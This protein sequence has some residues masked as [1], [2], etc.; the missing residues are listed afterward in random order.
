MNLFDAPQPNLFDEGF[1]NVNVL[2][3][4]TDESVSREARL[5]AVS[6]MTPDDGLVTGMQELTERYHRLIQLEGDGAVRREAAMNQ[7]T[8]ELEALGGLMQNTTGFDE[9]GSIAEGAS[10]ALRQAVIEDVTAREAFA[11]EQEALQN[12][13]NLAA[14]GDYTQAKILMNNL[15]GDPEDRIRD[16]NVKNLIA[17]RA[18]EKAGV[19]KESQGW[20]SD[21]VDFA[22]NFVPIQSGLS[23][24]GL[25]DIDETYK[26]WWDGLLPG[27]RNRTEAATLQ[28]MDVKDFAK[29]MEDLI[30]R[31]HD[32]TTLMGIHSN[33]EE[34]E[35]LSS[36]V[37]RTPSALATNAFTLVDNVGLLGVKELRAI[38]SVP[39]LLLRMGARKE[40]QN[41]I[42]QAAM[43]MTTEGAEQAA[44][45]TGVSVGEVVQGLSPKAINIDGPIGVVAPSTGAN[46]ALSEGR[47]MLAQL[48]AS[49]A[50]ARLTDDE[51][52]VAQASTLKKATDRPIKDVEYV[53]VQTADG[54][55]VN[56][57]RITIGKSDG[58]GYASERYAKN[59]AKSLGYT[60]APIIRDESGQ[61]FVQLDLSVREQGFATNVMNVKAT[62]FLSR[63]ILNSNMLSDE[64]LA[65]MA[66]VAGNKKGKLLDSMA[67]TLQAPFRALKSDE[68]ETLS[69]ILAVGENQG[70]WFTE[71]ELNVL[72]RRAY[73]RDISANEVKA[74]H[75]ARKINDMEFALRNDEAY[76]NLNIKGYETV[77][78]NTGMG[79]VDN[80]SAIVVR[81][82]ESADMGRVY[83]VTYKRHWTT[84]PTADDLKRMQNEGF[85][86]V[87]LQHPVKMADGTVIRQFV[88]K[89]NDIK[90][91]PLKQNQ[92]AYRAGGH[93]MYKGKYFVKQTVK[94]VQP[95]TGKA[96]IKSP[97]TYI[98]AETP[99]EASFW[100][101]KMEAARQVYKKGNATPS[102]IDA[103]FDGYA[104]FEKGDVFIKRMK[105]GDYDADHAFVVK[106]DREMPDEYFE[107]DMDIQ[108]F[109]DMDEAAYDGLLRTNGRMY[110]SKKGDVLKDWQGAQAPT[111]DPFLVIDKSLNN[112]AN[113]TSMSDYKISAM[114]RWINTYG[115]YLDLNDLNPDKI[116][117]FL[118]STVN[119]G[120]NTRIRQAAETQRE[121]IKRN[122]GWKSELDLEAEQYQ[123]NIANWVSGTD[124]LSPQNKAL[125][126][127]TDWWQEKDPIVGLRSMAFDM[128]MGFFNVAQLPMQIQTA[129]AATMLSPKSG[130]HGFAMYPSLRYFLTNA[131][132]ENA[133]DTFVKRGVHNLSGFDDPND[134][135]QMM[136]SAKQSGFFNVATTHNLVARYG[137]GSVT[138]SQV[139]ASDG[140]LRTTGR[141]F[142]NEGEI[143]NRTVAWRIA[144]DEARTKLSGV[145]AMSPAFQREVAGRAEKYSFSM[146][147]QSAA[148]WQKGVLSV[149]T[150][151]WAYNVRMMEAMLGGE[152]TK[153]QRV[154]LVIGQTLLYGSSGLPVMSYVTDK[155]KEHNAPNM[156]VTQSTLQ[157]FWGAADRGL[158][159]TALYYASGGNID[160]MVGKRYGTGGFLP[161][162]IKDI[163]GVSSYGEK[164]FYDIAAGATA[165]IMGTTAKGLFD[166][167]KY[168]S[169]ETGAEIEGMPLTRDAVL[170]VALNLSTVGN[171]YKAYMVHQYGTAMSNKGATAAADL[172]S[173]QAFATAMSLQSG[174]Q[175]QISTLMAYNKE[176]KK[177]RDEATKIIQNLRTRRLNEP[178]N[179]EELTR[180]INIHYQ[181][182]DEE[183]RKEVQQKVRQT[184]D[185]SLWDGM[186][187][188][189]Q[190]EQT[191]N[192]LMEEVENGVIN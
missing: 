145:D 96:F 53:T 85:M 135:K 187:R 92:L 76:K 46:E 38:A 52:A 181:L 126:V 67:E 42:A 89:G 112:I 74:Y 97:N 101:N 125:K 179:D 156:D 35:L 33:S 25:I 13:Q 138:G 124:P 109:A 178:D 58:D 50:T 32:K 49:T 18:M 170:S 57:A 132:S 87:N 62:N 64:L 172:P 106:F 150:Q 3:T 43:Q 77:E 121:I 55:Q 81:D 83:D 82:L 2:D 184:Q 31:L 37:E 99:A 6:K 162:T 36:L 24:S 90:I 75:T 151:F 169:A 91:S 120:V 188:K 166:V 127:V 78:F 69:Q 122:L 26:N 168:A 80:V 105:D 72:T 103:V 131:G 190:E 173:M 68:R 164:S 93:R 23:K 146:S 4:R 183:L 149:P 45:K 185:K 176:K 116:S 95:D 19:A 153:A 130:M 128:K 84:K 119:R 182:M 142:F 107:K 171:A 157:N 102:D 113:I 8:R 118:D 65:N 34:L 161:E 175:D 140:A 47:R 66:Q 40:A 98:V 165:G 9:D 79:V 16:T 144:W 60:D 177:I 41:L 110:Y 29:A 155:I 73:G 104:G 11:L 39:G 158:F 163:M 56:R 117:H 174:K 7:Q 129:F 94:G 147:S 111:L 15:E 152:F 14:A 27:V 154:R 21:L 115:K 114:E 136:R 133:L 70:K 139:M 88:A 180:E 143:A 191:A 189:I 159:D 71:S 123:R 167:V 137:P 30:P 10:L 61:Y 22:I 86:L 51:L 59:Y 148:W 141:F 48:Q 5:A 108:N 17:Y 134:F 1:E 186:A 192:A 44:R 100:A 63:R 28:N 12:I 160:A 20:F 54:S